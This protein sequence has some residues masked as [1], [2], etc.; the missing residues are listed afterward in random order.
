MLK[1]I[2]VVYINQV[3]VDSQHTMHNAID[4]DWPRMTSEPSL[5]QVLA[6]DPIYKLENYY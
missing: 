2:K 4:V 3:V 1:R 5:L 6:S